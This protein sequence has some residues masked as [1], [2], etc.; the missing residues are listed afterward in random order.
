[1]KRWLA[2]AIVLLL[3]RGRRR[4]LLGG[5]ERIVQ[6]GFPDRRAEL[7]VFVLF[8]CAAVCGIA[9]PVIYAVDSIPASPVRQASCCGGI[10]S[11]R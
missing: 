9:F 1:M 10:P 4:P 5:R 2:A 11:Y 6:P 3:G 8:G 7:I